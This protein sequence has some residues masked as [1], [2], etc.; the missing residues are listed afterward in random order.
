[1]QLV[2]DRRHIESHGLYIE[3]IC[4]MGS[5]FGEVLVMVES[6][7]TTKYRT[8]Y[9]WDKI[10]WKPNVDKRERGGEGEEVIHIIG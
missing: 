5:M 3:R 8:L 6:T 7:C 10:A 4:R 2:P 1:M 9:M